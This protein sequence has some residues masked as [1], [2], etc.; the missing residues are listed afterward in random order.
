MPPL[1]CSGPVE[2]EAEMRPAFA[3]IIRVVQDYE[4]VHLITINAS[5]QQA[6]QQFL[7][8]REV[9]ADN[10]TWHIAPTDNSWLRDNGPVYVA[11]DRELWIQNWRFD[12]WGGNFGDE[13]PYVNDNAIPIY[14]GQ[15][16]GMRVE[17]RIRI[18]FWKKATWSS[19]G[20]IPWCSIGIAR[21]I[22]ILA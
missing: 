1:G 12:A 11:D 14:I 17:D 18:T 2:W 22:A 6:A 20:R 15:Q 8:D 10:L 5:A 4:P 19:M 3:D 13:I 9:P 16:L 7:A 21:T